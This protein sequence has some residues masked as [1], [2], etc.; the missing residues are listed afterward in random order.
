MNRDLYNIICY[1]VLE[2]M[3]RL[4]MENEL[5]K[6]VQGKKSVILKVLNLWLFYKVC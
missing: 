2:A 4:K 6:T 3:F 1:T 5:C